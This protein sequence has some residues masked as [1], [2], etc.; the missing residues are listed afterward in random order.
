MIWWVA[1]FGDFD[2]K[3]GSR[4]NEE[5]QFDL[6]DLPRFDVD[7]KIFHIDLIEFRQWSSFAEYRRA[8]SE[9]IRRDYKKAMQADAVART[10]HGL[11]GLA[12]LFA[13]VAMRHHMARRNNL[14]FSR[15]VD[16][17]T[18]LGRLFVLDKNAFVSTVR[19]GGKC[20]AAFFGAEVGSK[21]YYLSGGTRN[22][23]LG[24]GS[25]LFLNVI[26]R[27]FSE[28]P[29]GE[30]LMGYCPKPLA[31]ASHDKG[32]LLYRRKLRVRSVNGMAFQLKPNQQSATTPPI[33][34][35]PQE[36]QPEPAKRARGA[37]A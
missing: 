17:V 33:A 10:E 6:E 15:V 4:W 37:H 14:P 25:Y 13:F 11:K 26:E 32:N 5:D 23:Q 34:K 19:I 9:N 7:R 36:A 8:L 16:Y 27:W 3:Y 30:F 18:H 35:T 1:Q 31:R 12:D 20:Y 2:Y 29:Q 21:L 24:A 28:H 22:N